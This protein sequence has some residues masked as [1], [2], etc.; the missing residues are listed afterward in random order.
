MNNKEVSALLKEL[1]LYLTMYPKYK[2][3]HANMKRYDRMIA[4]IIKALKHR[5][6]DSPDEEEV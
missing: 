3:C 2:A 6:A 5:G 1:E 4:E